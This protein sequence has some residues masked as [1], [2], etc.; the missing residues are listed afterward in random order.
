[1]QDGQAVLQK[2]QAVFLAGADHAFQRRECIGAP[3]TAI[4][5]AVVTSGNDAANISFARVVVGGKER[6]RV[7]ET[8]AT[9]IGAAPI[10]C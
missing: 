10:V 3:I 8:S 2:I 5:A 9:Q 4:D 6:R 7:P 1:M